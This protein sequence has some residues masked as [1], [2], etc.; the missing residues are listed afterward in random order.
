MQNQSLSYDFN[1]L[2][3]R[4]LALVEKQDRDRRLLY[5]HQKIYDLLKSSDRA[6]EINQKALERMN[7]WKEKQ[8][9]SDEYISDWKAMLS[10]LD[11]FKKMA[12]DDPSDNAVALRQNSP[13]AAFM[14][15]L[16][17]SK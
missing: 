1:P 6:E 8:L 4:R 14:K 11:Q 10:N 16:L 17:K 13:F 15:E 3:A 12:L 5:F 9:C 7:L 2:E